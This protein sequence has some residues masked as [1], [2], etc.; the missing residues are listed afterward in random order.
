MKV[1]LSEKQ[2]KGLNILIALALVEKLY[3]KKQISSAVY[4][5]I[6]SE[7]KKYLDND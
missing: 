5:N 2:R 3:I 1:N 7:Y 4:K 6:C